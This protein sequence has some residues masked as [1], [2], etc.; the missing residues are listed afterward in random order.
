MSEERT[1][2]EM[3]QKVETL[4]RNRVGAIPEGIIFEITSRDIEKAIE[5][6]LAD[7]GVDLDKDEVA[8]RCTWDRA[9]DSNMRSGRENGSNPFNI[10]VLT[11]ISEREKKQVDADNPFDQ[12]QRLILKNS[13]N[14][15][16]NGIRLSSRTA[17]SKA[18]AEFNDPRSQSGENKEKDVDVF[19]F[20]YRNKK[21]IYVTDIDFEQCFRYVMYD[22]GDDR[23][24]RV[25]Y[26]IVDK[27]YYPEDLSFT[28]RVV[29]QFESKN[30]KNSRKDPFRGFR[31]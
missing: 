9:F 24:N 1:Q 3:Y 28:I 25:Q 19:W 8:V 29:K 21:N 12:I 23:R 31:R 6:F 5:A 17:L 2:N 14:D 18:I 22:D 10:S 15:K 4:V 11:K 30:Y 26:D 7:R 16:K 13:S 20:R 27:R